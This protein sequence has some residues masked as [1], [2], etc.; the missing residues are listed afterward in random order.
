MNKILSTILIALL[1]TTLFVGCGSSDDD[2]SVNLVFVVSPDLAYNTA[3][4]IQPDTANLTRQGLNRS[5]QMATYLK[6]KV[7]SSKNAT[8]IYALSP[9][10]HLQTQNNYPDMTAIGYI[11]QFALLNQNTLP[12]STSS[13]YTANTFPI[14]VS[15]TLDSLPQNVSI[16]STFCTNCSGL[17]FNNTNG[18]NDALV[19]D[20]IAKK[21]SGFYVFSAPWE[22]IHAMMNDINV[23][24]GYNLDLPREYSGSNTIYTI[25]IPEFGGTSLKV[26][27]SNLNP[28]VSYPT[29]PKPVVSATCTNALQPYFKSERIKGVDS[30]VVPSNANTNQTVYIVR[31]AEAHPDDEFKFENGSFVAA[32]QWRALD[33]SRTLK[34]KINTPDMVY[35][36]D[37]AQW[38][39]HPLYGNFS[40]VRPS[41]T[42]LPFA[43]DNNVPYSLVSDFQL[44]TK[45]T[46]VTTAKKTSDFFFTGGKFSNKTILLAWESG[47][48]RPLLK[49]LLETYGGI[50]VKELDINLPNTGW[51][52]NDYDTIW[53][54]TLDNQGNLSVDN[55]LCEGIESKSLP[56]T[57]P[58]FE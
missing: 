18:S 1:S 34:G 53:R 11:Q 9:M 48:I 15:Y 44:M 35:S 27:N 41:L 52:G 24:H 23:K 29:L 8:S 21:I 40:Y 39:N 19:S 43:I 32:G 10:T 3:G 54:V 57:A 46:D 2:K 56:S 50:N 5:L 7:L 16:P 51:P 26:Y 6:E 17:D 47:H 58:M 4:D 12:L 22:T 36:I 31:H 14:K 33:L 55:E 49:Q 42:V 20:I 13:S 37:P 45:A 28:S 38:F 30:V 25:S